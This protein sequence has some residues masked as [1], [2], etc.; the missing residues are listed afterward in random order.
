MAAFILFGGISFLGFVAVAVYCFMA[1][2]GLVRVHRDV[3]RAWSNIG[4]LLKQRRDELSKLTD[5]LKQYMDHESELLQ[6]LTE[7]RSKLQKADDPTEAAEAEELS[8][9]IAHAINAR[10]ENYPDLKA[11]NNFN[12]LQDRIAELEDQIADRREYYNKTVN[13]H[14]TRINQIPHNIFAT[15]LGYEDIDSF[16]VD[17]EHKEDVNV[18]EALFDEKTG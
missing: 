7:A 3:E 10:A 6:T 5:V 15:M 8:E 13:I 18:R 1:Y 4:V 9:Q 11:S 17:P 16:T 12:Q 2:N 14:N